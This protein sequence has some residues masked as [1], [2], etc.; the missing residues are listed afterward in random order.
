VYWPALSARALSFDDNQY[1]TDNMLVQN[2]SFMSVKRFLFEVLKPS[3]VK[4]YYQPLTMISLMLDSAVGGGPDN[5]RQYH[6]TSLA[7]HIINTALIIVLLY[8]LFGRPWAAAAAGLLFGVHPLTVEPIPWAGER[9]TLLATFFALWCLVFYVNYVRKNNRKFYWGG[10]LTYILALMSKPTTVALPV[11]MLLMD[12]WPLGRKLKFKNQNSKLRNCISFILEKIPFF[13]VGGVSA[14]ITYISQSRT[15]LAVLPS[16]Y[17]PGIVPKILCH[18]I[19][20]YLYKIIWPA[21]LSSHYA[22][23]KE[24]GFANPMMLAGVVGTGILIALLVISLLW[25]RAALTGWLIFFVAIFPAMGV[26]GY[27]NVIASDKFVYLPSVGLLMILAAFLSRLCGADSIVRPTKQ[28]IV[29][30][31]VVLILSGAEA[32][33]TRRYLVYWRDSVS[34][35]RNMERITPDDALVLNMLGFSLQTEGK[36]DEAISYYQQAIKAEPNEAGIYYNMGNAL[37][38]K[39][40]L[41][42]AVSYYY[43]SLQVNP[44]YAEPHNNLGNVLL[45][46]G[47]FDEA[48]KQYLE[49]EKIEP[50]YPDIQ[51]NLGNMFLSAGNF[52]DAVSHYRRALQLRP[53]DAE[54][55]YK[56]GKAFQSQ[57]RYD[58]AMSQ[59]YEALRHRPDYA[60][61]HK[62]IADLLSSLGNLDL[63][64]TH[65]Y[66]ALHTEPNNA[67]ILNNLGIALGTQNKFNE[68]IKHFRKVLELKPDNAEAYNNLGIALEQTGGFDEA[69]DCYRKAMQLKPDWPLPMNGLAKILATHPDVNKRNVAE[70]ISLA[71]RGAEL[72]KHQNAVVL[73]TLATAYAA[74]GQFDKAAATAKKALSSALAQQ[75]KVLAER[76]RQQMENYKKQ[77]GQ[78]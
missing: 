4:G 14:I 6:R 46:Q 2:P 25:T 70:A 8:L 48:L 51:Y 76:I 9:K 47:K 31:S 11:V 42:E 52:D 62:E 10:M 67:D 7:L 32:F 27:T 63:A 53:R 1:L 44:D 39:G 71:E 21:N 30:M 19:I 68:A 59:F 64:V 40:R 50:D 33:A 28:C 56:L 16:Q 74:A 23:P 75:N 3:T 72:T 34:L 29:T 49:A 73:D 24:W 78:Q 26:I 5:L 12:Y 69:I 22:L 15:A 66:Q 13:A 37:R 57:G 17:N 35:F 45:A 61:A 18:N 55:H 43:R 38:S 54:A 58:E 77:A 60:E 20:F 36:L 41:D 65:Y